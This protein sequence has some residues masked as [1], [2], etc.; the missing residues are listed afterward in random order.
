M[1]NAHFIF[2]V[3]RLFRPS[4]MTRPSYYLYPAMYR[5][6]FITAIR[7]FKSQKAYTFI[8]VAGLSIGLACA[9]LIALW[10]NDEL[11]FDQ[12]HEQ[13][14]QL[15]QLNRHVTFSDGNIFTW[16]SVPKPL[17]QVLEKEI[18][19]VQD[20]ELVQWNNQQIVSFENQAYRESSRYLDTA[21]F[22]MFSFPL[23]VGKSME[24][25][26]DPDAAVISESLAIKYFGADWQE[27]NKALGQILR[28]NNQWDAK[29]TGVFK[30]I[31]KNSTLRFDIAFAMSRFLSTRPWLDHWGKQQSSDL[32]PSARRGK[33]G[34]RK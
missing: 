12:F 18:P 13:G 3:I 11:K 2:D 25:L 9:V 34:S 19:E 4:S 23:I 28:V 22:D 26:K 32:C 6:Y 10:V 8:N 7:N 5:N 20:A 1:A 33:S 21:F 14:D 30:D 16:Q 27:N 29:V 17:A 15:Y 31:P 24:V